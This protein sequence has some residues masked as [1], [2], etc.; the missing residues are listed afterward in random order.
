MQATLLEHC[1]SK[2]M[3]FIDGDEVIDANSMK[4]ARLFCENNADGNMVYARPGKFINF[5]HD[6]KHIAYSLN[7][8]SPWFHGGLPHAFLVH[9]DIPGLN[10]LSLHTM[11]MDGFGVCLSLDTRKYQGR[12]AVLDDVFVHHF[13]NAKG[14]DKMYE[15]LKMPHARLLGDSAEDPWFSGVM[16]DDMVLER[17]KSKLPS[18]LK[19]HPDRK[20]KRIRITKTKPHYEFEVI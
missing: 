18:I 3:L 7:P 5:W 12:Q 2:W 4:Q 20:K 13:G 8:L 14:V 10:F 15:K 1:V 17:F 16:P 6:F 11:A 19:G 9:R